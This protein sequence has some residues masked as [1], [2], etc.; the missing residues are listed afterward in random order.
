MNSWEDLYTKRIKGGKVS[1][2]PM[3]DREQSQLANTTSQREKGAGPRSSAAPGSSNPAQHRFIPRVLP[4]KLTNPYPAVLGRIRNALSDC[5]ANI[6]IETKQTVS[7]VLVSGAARNEGATF[8]SYHLAMFLAKEFN[9]KVLY[10]DTNLDRPGIPRAQNRPGVYSYLSEEK[11]LSS[12]IVKTEYPGFY[13]LPSGAGKVAKNVNSNMLTR[14]P[15][16]ALMDFCR[17]NF[18]VTIID[19][20]PLTS[21]PVMVECA[22][23]VDMTLLVCRYGHSRQEVSKLAIEKLQK[24]GV[25]SIGVILNDR[26]FPVPQKIYQ[27]LG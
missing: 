1:V 5:W 2:N 25:T 17:D 26:K 22:R 21:S 18:T 15:L 10:V 12:L 11:E 27:L 16:S 3:A 24:F 23:L 8:I 14:E 13:L 4:L 20:Q 9:M 7:A 19:G 6:L